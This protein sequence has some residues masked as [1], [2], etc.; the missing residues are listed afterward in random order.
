MLTMRRICSLLAILAV[1]LG[2]ASSAAYS[3]GMADSM[4]GGTADS[5]NQ[6]GCDDCA[7]DDD[8][9]VCVNTA[10]VLFAALLPTAAT[11]PAAGLSRRSPPACEGGSGLILVPVTGPP[12]TRLG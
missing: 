12:R 9:M 4:I 1:V 2:A 8:V 5:M 10:C 7:S 3:G 11:M 6:N